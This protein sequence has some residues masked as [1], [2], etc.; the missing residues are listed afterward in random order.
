[1][2]QTLGRRPRGLQAISSQ[3]TVIMR[4]SILA[5]VLLS[6]LS[7]ALGGQEATPAPQDHPQIPR[8]PGYII[9]GTTHKASDQIAIY[10]SQSEDPT[11][12][13]NYQVLY[14]K[15]DYTQV[16][17]ERRGGGTGNEGLIQFML[18]N[19]RSKQGK[20]LLQE[21][22]VENGDLYFWLPPNY[23]VAFS[24]FD[25]GDN[26]R[27]S[28]IENSGTNPIPSRVSETRTTPPPTE[29]APSSAIAKLTQVKVMKTEVT[30]GET[31]NVVLLFD[32]LLTHDATISMQS[33]HP[34]AAP[35]EPSITAPKDGKAGAFALKTSPAAPDTTVTLTAQC[36]G[37]T[38]STTF[39]IK[40]PAQTAKLDQFW[41]AKT[42]LVGG[43][44]CQAI[45][46]FDKALD[47]A[48][49][50]SLASSAPSLIPLPPTITAKKGEQGASLTLKS[51][52]VTSDTQVTLTATCNGISQSAQ[53]TLTASSTTQQTQPQSPSATDPA[54]LDKIVCGGAIQG[55]KPATV[56][57]SFD[58]PVAADRKV[59][60][61]SSNSNAAAI[62]ASVT[63]KKGDQSAAVT[64][65]TVAVSSPADVTLTA[66][67][68][69]SSQYVAVQVIP[70][71]IANKESDPT[72][73]S[74][75]AV[76]AD[77]KCSANTIEGGASYRLT[78]FFDRPLTMS[79][80][81]T[82]S[83]SQPLAAPMPEPI[84]FKR[85]DQSKSITLTSSSVSALTSVQVTAQCE[86]VAKTTD[87]QLK[88][89]T[90]AQT[91]PAQPAEGSR[92][93]NATNPPP[94]IITQLLSHDKASACG[95]VYAANSDAPPRDSAGG[96]VI[97]IT[98]AIGSLLTGTSEVAPYD[99]FY[100]SGHCL[101]FIATGGSLI[102]VKTNPAVFQG[103]RLKNGWKVKSFVAREYISG[104]SE[105]GWSWVKKPD[106]GSTDPYLQLHL[107]ATARDNI[108]VEL[109][110]TIE[111]P[112]GTDPYADH[113]SR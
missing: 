2:L 55:G 66:R 71:L 51:K 9:T 70:P 32:G 37:I 89:K 24:T 101:T 53:V 80:T 21:T 76:L 54:R 109:E 68:G 62:P 17:Y 41:L 11:D 105:A 20:L 69:A 103:F 30:A 106:L 111:G 49:L 34:D 84:T 108:K 18:D 100:D 7:T 4:S 104:A 23:W 36:D 97:G 96:V 58:R 85:G 10:C 25:R 15:G 88:P 3:L 107:W 1:M 42:S 26:Y 61:S 28:I 94:K 87:I 6:V 98:G 79:K 99:R 50:I 72:K 47:K 92:T 110:I 27:V 19:I 33:S 102:G 91:L 77:L 74:D 56:T 57:V 65:K 64:M 43:D 12:C 90:V 39:A 16:E 78:L 22:G 48:T 5:F 67:D 73:K 60:L 31:V 38:Q 113:P 93:T 86:S 81:V 45:P 14:L 59:S 52:P 35:V 13:G 40:S 83:S 46:H 95:A 63:F 29:P 82:L 8:P 112:E 75:P 44:S